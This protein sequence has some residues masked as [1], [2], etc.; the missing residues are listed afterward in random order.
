MSA[1]YSTTYDKNI[2]SKIRNQASLQTLSHEKLAPLLSY[3]LCAA[4]PLLAKRSKG[5]IPMYPLRSPLLYPK[6]IL[7][8][9]RIPPQHQYVL[10][11]DQE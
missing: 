2:Y 3:S 8:S 5:N 4:L 9:L 6:H 10:E 1:E 7:R 11:I